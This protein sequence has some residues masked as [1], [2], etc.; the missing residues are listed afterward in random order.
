MKKIYQI[1]EIEVLV[2]EDFCQAY[3]GESENGGEAGVLGNENRIFDRSDVG[4]E[5]NSNSLWDN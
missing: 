3:E 2:N 4:N 1:P 5:D